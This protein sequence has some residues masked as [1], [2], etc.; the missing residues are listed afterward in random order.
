MNKVLLGEKMNS[1]RGASVLEVIF[2]I[3]LVMA[4]TPFMFNQISEMAQTVKD[5]SAAR[6]IVNLRSDIVNYVRANQQNWEDGNMVISDDDLH[7]LAPDAHAGFIYKETIQGATMTE[8]YLAFAIDASKYRASNIA[9]YIGNDAAIVH[10]DNVAYSDT[11]SVSAPDAFNSGDLIY[12]ISRDFEGDNQNV[13]LHRGTGGG[14][15]LNHMQRPLHMNGNDMVNVGNVIGNVN[16]N[17]QITTGYTE[18]LTVGTEGSVTTE[19][20]I[21]QHG[22]TIKASTINIGN[23]LSV[24]LQPNS[25]IAGFASINIVPDDVDPEVYY[26]KVHNPN[27]NAEVNVETSYVDTS[28]HTRGNL[29]LSNSTIS[30]LDKIIVRDN[31]ISALSIN[32]SIFQIKRGANFVVSG[33]ALAVNVNEFFSI[34]PSSS[35]WTWARPESDYNFV[36]GPTFGQIGLR[37]GSVVIDGEYARALSLKTG[38]LERDYR[39]TY[40][41][42]MIIGCVFGQ[43]ESEVACNF[44]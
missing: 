37:G 6:D 27:N 40:M 32:S 36:N 12:R 5:V 39:D 44:N 4:I 13:Y 41:G 22:A 11:W 33:D 10:G 20:A 23:D 9:K 24:D 30:G 35:K 1:Q 28:F 34:G 8:V 16:K 18:Y 29:N 43:T 2:A 38:K 19:G 3:A 14:D 21:F 42:R 7:D 25:E 15:N 31:T 17:A 26:L